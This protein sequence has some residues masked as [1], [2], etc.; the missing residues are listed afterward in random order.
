MS[1]DPWPYNQMP[2]MAQM[3]RLESV[4][5]YGRGWDG[6]DAAPI[7]PRAMEAAGAFLRALRPGEPVPCVSPFPNGSIA[8]YW[9]RG[10]AYCE[11]EFDATGRATWYASEGEKEAFGSGH[12]KVSP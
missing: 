4:R 1:G 2:G 9:T 6:Y 12:L 7:S 3:E 5:H 11:L 8:L 10:P